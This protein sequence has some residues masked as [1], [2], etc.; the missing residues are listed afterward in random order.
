ML[1]VSFQ[2]VSGFFIF[3]RSETVG[4]SAYKYVSLQLFE[5]ETSS[6]GESI[7]ELLW[8][9]SSKRLRI[10]ESDTTSSDK[11]AEPTNTASLVDIAAS[12]L[13]STSGMQIQKWSIADLTLGLYFLSVRHASQMAGDTFSGDLVQ[14]DTFVSP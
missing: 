2:G 1:Q 4:T 9:L 11:G 5:R 7:S 8:C 12:I 10:L 14:S 6:D 13:R 3:P